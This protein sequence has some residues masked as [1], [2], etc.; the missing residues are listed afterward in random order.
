MAQVWK[1]DAFTV[2]DDPARVDLDV[3]HGYLARSYWA[4]G[5]PRETVS[6]SIAHSLVFVLL[7]GDTQVGFARAITD[8][9]TMAYLA[10]VF[11][12]EQHRGKGLGVWLME[13][14]MA[15]PALQ[16]LRVFRLATKDAHGL[17][18]RFGF[19]TPSHPERLMEIIDPAVYAAD[20]EDP[21]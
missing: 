6:R 12:L 9:A 18:E 11:V 17:Y 13:C 21:A 15:H 8:R 7:Y 2:T 4:R 5:V 1:R 3:V 20:K 16:G 14:V 19:R 10:D